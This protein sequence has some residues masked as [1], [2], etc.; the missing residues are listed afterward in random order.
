M[1]PSF[2]WMAGTA[3]LMAATASRGTAAQG[4]SRPSAAAATGGAASTSAA[5]DA[6][7][8]RYTQ[9][10]VRFMQG[11]IAHHAQAVVMTR[12][13]PT[14]G[15]RDDVRRVALRTQLSQQDEMAMMRRWLHD[16]GEAVPA[17]SGEHAMAGMDHAAMPETDAPMMPG[18]LTPGQLAG[19]DAATGAGFDMLFLQ[20]MIRHH[21]G[22]LAMVAQ[23]LATPGAGQEPELFRFASDVDADQRAEIARMEAML[24]APAP[25]AHPR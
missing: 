15:L 2:R 19:L 13:V 22:A 4:Q 10:D 24:G 21:E 8:P 16:R 9:A 12:M 7:Q 6:Q 25:A 20:Y 1:K 14:H 18:M 23:L 11:M 3:L 5:P 17:D